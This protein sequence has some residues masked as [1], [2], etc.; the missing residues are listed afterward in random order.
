L[1]LHLP[2]SAGPAEQVPSE[3]AAQVAALTRGAPLMPLVRMSTHRQ[4]HHLYGR[5]A[6][7]TD[8]QSSQ[9]S[10]S[11]PVGRSEGQPGE[12][13]QVLVDEVVAETLSPLSNQTTAWSEIEVELQNGDLDLL[14]T[15]ERRLETAGARRAQQASKL[16]RVLHAQLPTIPVGPPR[17][18]VGRST[19]AGH[20][21][22]AYLVDQID[23][24]VDHDPPARQDTPDA[25]H[26]MRVAARRLRSVLG[27]YGPVFDAEPTAAMRD[28]LQWLGEQLGPVRDLEVLADRLRALAGDQPPELLIGPVTRRLELEV[29]DRARPAHERMM[30]AL[31]DPRY[32]QL[33]DSLDRLAGDPPWTPLADLPAEEALPPLLSR[34]V[35]RVRRRARRAADAPLVSLP[36]QAAG[37]SGDALDHVVAH[38]VDRQT[39]LHDVRKAAKQARYAA[40]TLEPVFG[41]P[42][43]RLADAMRTVQDVLG[44]QRDAAIATGLLR[45]IGIAAHLAGENAFTWGRMHAQ[46]E[47]AAARLLE[48]A[49]PVLAQALRRKLRS[50]LPAPA[51]AGLNT[52][53]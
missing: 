31:D 42:A 5:R 9:S 15:L 1:E 8:S 27:T 44:E 14:D 43:A 17:T 41:G 13:A 25:V 16:A 33:L 52:S 19:P 26:Q 53:H 47:T 39:A 37:P 2:L 18:R 11:S 23:R 12:L 40:E 35:H 49:E 45:E 4:V 32:F 36:G 38:R 30:A 21:V 50:W 28:Q 46:E 10:Q 22:M 48:Q 24:L 29:D 20:V 51:H 6:H 3:L 7:T 34:A